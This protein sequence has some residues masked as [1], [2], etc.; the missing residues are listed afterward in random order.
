MTPVVKTSMR[1]TG[2]NLPSFKKV[3]K[4]KCACSSLVTLQSLSV[5]G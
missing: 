5:C 4:S 2:F 1:L 3:A